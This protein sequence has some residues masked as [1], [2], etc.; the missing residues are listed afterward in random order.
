MNQNQREYRKGVLQVLLCMVIWGFLPIYWKALI[1]INSW[2]IIVYRVLMVF[3]TAL[4]IALRNHTWSEIWAPLREDKKTVRTLFIAGLIITVN[5]STY[6]WAVNAGYIIQTSVGYYIEPL[7][8]CLIGII[9]F[10]EKVTKYKVIAMVFAAVAVVTIIA[11]F[12]QV[13]GIALGLAATFSVYAAIKRSVTIDPVLSMIYE[14]MWLAPFAFI[15]AVYLEVTGKGAIAVAAPYQYVLL[16]I[17]GI[18]TAGPL[19]LFAAG[20][21]RTSMF[22]LG[23]VEYVSPTL[24]L[25]LGIFLYHESTDMVQMIAFCIIWI[26]LVFFTYGELKDSRAIEE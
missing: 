12:G 21:Q 6:I 19:I 4:L 16:L 3:V 24:Q 26:G 15:L 8:V 13:P 2:V 14:T 9:L 10:H 18:F 20:A 17:C 5:W 22:I 1:P 7:A 23:L 11:H 25:I